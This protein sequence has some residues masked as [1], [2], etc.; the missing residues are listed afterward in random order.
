MWTLINNNEVAEIEM[1][2]SSNPKAAYIR[3]KDG[4][5][6]DVVG[7]RKEESRGCQDSHEGR[8]AVDGP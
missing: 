4:R 2:L 8:S 5:G 7:F 3:S 1:W 6:A